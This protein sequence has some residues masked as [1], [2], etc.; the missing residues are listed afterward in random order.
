MARSA[1]AQTFSA[2]YRV[3]CQPA[4]HVE[5]AE[6]YAETNG[7]GVLTGVLDRNELRR[8]REVVTRA[9]E[10]KA[11]AAAKPAEPAYGNA[12]SPN[13]H[14]TDL[15]LGDPVF[16]ELLEHEVALRLVRHLLGPNIRLSDFTANIV[17]PGA[18]AMEMHA[19]QGYVTTPWPDWPLS[20]T[21]VWV[22]DNFT[23]ETGATRVKPDSGRYD[24]GPESNLPYPEAQPLACPAGSIIALD[25][26]IWHQSGPNT[27]ERTR[28]IALFATYVRPFILPRIDWR[29]RVPPDLRDTLTPG[30]REMLGFEVRATEHRL[31]RFGRQI[32]PNEQK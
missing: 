2:M 3:F 18:E 12:G 16:R 15:V 32:W 10:A 24:H 11:S 21:I 27:T 22:I 29:E 4:K 20:V 1:P 8:V 13:V 7:I 19:D 6:T 30:L 9:M 26:R 23:A 17:L 28:R 14:L 25:G 31:T 5:V